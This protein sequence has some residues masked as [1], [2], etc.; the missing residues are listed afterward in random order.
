MIEV[1]GTKERL[2]LVKVLCLIPTSTDNP[3]NNSVWEQSLSIH[4]GGLFD[5]SFG[6]KRLSLILYR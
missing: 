6:V 1:D 2:Q 5:I 4:W 3:I